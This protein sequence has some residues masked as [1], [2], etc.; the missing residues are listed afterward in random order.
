MAFLR[1]HPTFLADN[2]EMYRALVPPARVHGTSM[3]DHM[4]AMLA[5]ERAHA[6]TV[7]AQAERVLAAGRAAMGLAARVHEAVLAVIACD[8]LVEC[9]TV[10]FPSLLAVDAACLCIETD[11]PSARR[12]PDGFVDS[13]LG[14]VRVVF[15]ADP[16]QAALIHGEAMGLARHQA[17]IRIPV[18]GPPALLALASRD[19]AILDPAQGTTSLGFLGRVVATALGR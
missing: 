10:E 14:T 18:R 9:I 17:L 12:L 3:A 8:D 5:A 15:E 13:L 1:A 6:Q 11:H 19:A 4:A 16:G 7:A 2:P